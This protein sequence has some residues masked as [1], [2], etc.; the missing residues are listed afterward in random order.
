M[1]ETSYSQYSLYGEPRSVRI[2]NKTVTHKPINFFGYLGYAGPGHLDAAAGLPY[3]ISL[4]HP[5]N[6]MF[7]E[8]ETPQGI[9]LEEAPE[10]PVQ[11]LALILE[12]MSRGYWFT[13]V[14]EIELQKV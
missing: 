1:A 8:K 5:W 13:T 7:H 6:I 11:N 4:D 2:G 10:Q 3:V 9:I 12:A 14:E